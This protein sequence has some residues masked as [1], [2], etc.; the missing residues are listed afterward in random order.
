[1]LQAVLLNT[2]VRPDIPAMFGFYVTVS[3][4]LDRLINPEN[5]PGRLHAAGTFYFSRGLNQMKLTG[6]H[7]DIVIKG[8]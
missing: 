6:S 7:P 4:K 1:M 8:K 5:I 2:K 3:L